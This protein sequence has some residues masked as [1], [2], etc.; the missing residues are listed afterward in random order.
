MEI[1]EEIREWLNSNLTDEQLKS[2]D[3]FECEL[4][5]DINKVSIANRLRP[6]CSCGFKMKVVELMGYGELIKYWGCYNCN[7][8]T[9]IRD[10]KSDVQE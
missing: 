5:G 4:I 1:S 2:F 3:N 9:V 7:I 6:T 10:V 8:D